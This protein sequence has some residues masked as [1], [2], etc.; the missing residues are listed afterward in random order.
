MLS[1]REL[2]HHLESDASLQDV[3]A[4]RARIALARRG[5][6]AAHRRLGARLGLEV[7][8]LRRRLVRRIHDGLE[9]LWTFALDWTFNPASRRRPRLRRA[10][11]ELWISRAGLIGRYG[12]DPHPTLHG[13]AGRRFPRPVSEAVRRR[14]DPRRSCPASAP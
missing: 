6:S 5:R 14:A 11:D 7:V 8:R 12:G 1:L 13:P 4:V 9:N 3:A 10:H 2:A